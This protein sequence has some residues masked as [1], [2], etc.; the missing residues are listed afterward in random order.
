[1]LAVIGGEY[2]TLLHR[3]EIAEARAVQL[4]E[5]EIAALSPQEKF[6]ARRAAFAEQQRQRILA[7]KQLQ[8]ATALGQPQRASVP[9]HATEVAIT[10]QV[11]S[12]ATVAKAGQSIKAK[13]LVRAAKFYGP[14]GVYLRALLL[15]TAIALVF[16]QKTP[17]KVPGKPKRQPI[18]RKTLRIVLGVCAGVMLIAGFILLDI[19]HYAVGFIKL[20]Y[21][22]TAAAVL[23]SGGLA[24]LL[25]ASNRRPDFG[26]T[27]ERKKVETPNSIYFATAD[28]GWITIANPYRGTLVLGGAGAGKSYSIG[29]PM[30]EQFAYRNFAGLIYDFKFPVLAEVAQKAVVLAERRKK[31]EKEKADKYTGSALGKAAARL[32][33]AKEEEPDEKPVQLHIINFRD[34]TRSERVNPLRAADMPVVAFAEEYSR[35][36]INNLN[37]TS[38]K[39]MEF[40]DTSAVAYLTSIIWFYRKNYPQYCTIPHVVATAMYDDF[41]HVLSMLN[42]DLECGDMARSLITAVKQ[43][44]EKQ[45]AAVVG[46]LQVILTKINSPEIVWVLTPDEF[47]PDENLR[48]GFSL[49]LN[50]RKAPKLLCLGNDPTLKTTFSP[51]ISCIITVAIKLMNQQDKHRSYV[52][53]DEAATIYV[54]GLEDLPNTGRSNRIATV[55]MTQDLSQM[56]DAYGKEKMNVM[57][58]S[59]GNQFFGKVNSLETAKFISELV[60]REEKEITS[61]GSSQG[62]AGN[63]SNTTNQTTSYQERS[64]VRVQDTISLQQGEFIGQTVETNSTFFQ[65]IID[66][67][68]STNERFPLHPM[69][70]FAAEGAD[71]AAALTKT[72]QENFLQ[73]RQQV[74]ETIQQF[75]NTLAG[76]SQ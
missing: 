76:A 7:A 75:P 24:G 55:Y 35:A 57:I 11:D 42:T 62:S 8:A 54:P 6:A 56:T 39:K 15:L 18:A 13:L 32:S 21:P 2:Y 58:A 20:G 67:T 36:I 12:A 40:F 17:A 46:T 31:A 65:G 60:G 28:G 9:T 14:A 73:V 50:D 3:Q 23:A 22:L 66:R 30:V 68:D 37:P 52:F 63:R 48:E 61:T 34:L 38:I 53:L 27:T 44:A 10:Q 29:E 47:N 43:K 4:A 69:M 70:T 25:W 1:M 64:L 16:V 45:I 51:V 19:Q 26:L 49:A 72:V 71:P 59:L 5:P 74:L 33:S 41:K